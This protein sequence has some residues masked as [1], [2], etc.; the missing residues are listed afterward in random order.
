M[1]RCCTRIE[2]GPTVCDAETIRESELQRAT[3]QVLNFLVRCR[4]DIMDILME[5]IKTALADDNSG[6][7]EKINAVLAEKQKQLTNL[8]HAKKDYSML[9][10]EIELLNDKKQELL[11]EKAKNEGFKTRIKELKGLHQQRKCRA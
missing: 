11:T 6:G 9:A 1:W 5:N 8:V 4:E 10:D 2:N 7:L 3:I